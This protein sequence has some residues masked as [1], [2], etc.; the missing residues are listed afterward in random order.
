MKLKPGV[1]LGELTP[2]MV[3]GALIVKSVYQ[4]LDPAC[5]CTVTSANDSKHGDKSLHYEGNALDFRTHDFTA[6][7]LYLVQEVKSS[8]GIHFDVVLEGVGTANEHLHVEY[9]PKGNS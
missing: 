1:L 6:N 8:L 5:S 2:Q 4:K 9:Q 3:M 7:K